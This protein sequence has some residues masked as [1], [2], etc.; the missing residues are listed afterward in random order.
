MHTL[1][2]HILLIRVESESNSQTEK[3]AKNR[4]Y[5]TMTESYTIWMVYRAI[6]PS[7]VYVGI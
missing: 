7:Q 5:V 6:K 4:V 1:D 2:R 3:R